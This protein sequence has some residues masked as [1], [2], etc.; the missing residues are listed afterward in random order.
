MSIGIV[1]TRYGR[2]RGVELDAPF[3]DVTLFKGIPYAAPPIGRLRWAPPA[4]PEPW[5]G[6]RHCAEYGAAAVQRFLTDKHSSE[7]YY[8]GTPPMSEDCLYLNVATAARSD[9][10]KRP[11]YLWFHGGGLTNCFSYE[12]QFNPEVLAGKGVVVVTVGQRLNLFGH[13]ALPQLSAEYGSSGNYGLMDQLKALDWVYE[14]IEAFGGDPQRIT[15]GGQSG[16]S[17][18]AC[19]MAASPASRG[20]VKRVICQSGLKWMYR[21]AEP[22]EAE[23]RGRK[24][25]EHVGLDPDA[26]L[27]ELRSLDALT[28]FR[29]APRAIMPGDMVYDSDLIPLPTM[30]ECF[31]SHLGDVDFLNGANL[32]EAEVFAG[33]M[34][35]SFDEPVRPSG[36]RIETAAEFHAHFKS[37]LGDLYGRYDFPNLVPV[38]DADAGRTARRLASLGLAGGESNNFGR[39]TMLNRIFGKYRAVRQPESNVYT[40]L[41]SHILPSLPDAR[42]ANPDPGDGLAWHSGELWFVFGSLREGV[43]PSR[44]WRPAD[45]RLADIASS[46][47]ANFIATG[48]PNGDGLPQWPTSGEDYGYAEIGAEAGDEIRVTTGADGPLDRLLKEFVTREYRIT[49]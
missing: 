35:G 43:P 48:D 12:V 15:V 26:S 17:L 9:D 16:G 41:W 5:A 13:L 39:S 34:S 4:D 8:M 36:G 18:K 31:E 22:A 32:G 30:R 42:G 46:Y 3:D 37:L 11:V 40:Y 45:F 44:P 7:Y 6:I 14:N 29:D 19:A 28:V 24:Y 49:L 27:E 47:W 20:R 38:T 1:H 10:E 2:M 21:F 25:L 33:S 23:A